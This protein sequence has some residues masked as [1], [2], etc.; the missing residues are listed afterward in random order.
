VTS[1]GARSI[2]PV[3]AMSQ[4]TNAVPVADSLAAQRGAVHRRPRS[5]ASQPIRSSYAV[6]SNLCGMLDSEDYE[7]LGRLLV[8]PPSW[9]PTEAVFMHRVIGSRGGA[10]V[11][12]RRLR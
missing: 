5:V 10:T 7:D 9:A 1:P 4:S 2:R 11:V 6:R 8:S 3:C 12:L